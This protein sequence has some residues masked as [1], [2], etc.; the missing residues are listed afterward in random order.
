M[1]AA[2]PTQTTPAKFN[3]RHPVLIY[4]CLFSTLAGLS[5]VPYMTYLGAYLETEIN[6]SAALVGSVWTVLGITGAVTG[7]AV[8]WIADRHGLPIALRGI[9]IAFVAGALIMVFLPLPPLVYGA[10]IGFGL[11]YFTLW[12]LISTYVNQ[13]LAPG[14]AMRVIGISLVCVGVAAAVGNWAAGLWASFGHSF[15]DIYLI[16]AVIG[17]AMFVL[18][19]AMPTRKIDPA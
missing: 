6:H 1:R 5:A 9:F 11:M 7:I 15:A 10:G 19:S 4:A 8:G 16:I 12:G 14:A 18:V 2:E 3:L 17:G 13:F